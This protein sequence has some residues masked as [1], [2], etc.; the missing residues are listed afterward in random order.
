MSRKIKGGNSCQRNQRESSGQR[1]AGGGSSGQ[2]AEDAATGLLMVTTSVSTCVMFVWRS[3]MGNEAYYL[4]LGII[5]TAG[6]IGILAL[7]CFIY[8]LWQFR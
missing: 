3:Q 7:I 2:N 6:S 4:M 5:A 1:D 8:V